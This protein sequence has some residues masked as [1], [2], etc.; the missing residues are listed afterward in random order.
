MIKLSWYVKSVFVDKLTSYLNA[1]ADRA[2][3]RDSIMNQLKSIPE[4]R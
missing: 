3:E 1:C 2:R 4:H